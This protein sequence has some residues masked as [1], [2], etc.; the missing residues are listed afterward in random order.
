MFAA[1]IKGDLSGLAIQGRASEEAAGAHAGDRPGVASPAPARRVLRARRRG[2]RHAA[3]RDRDLVR[4]AAAVEGARAQRDA[5]ELAGAGL[6]LR[7]PQQPAAARPEGLGGAAEIPD[8]RRGQGAAE[9]PGWGLQGHRRGDPAQAGRTRAA[10]RRRVLRRARVRH[11]RPAPADPGRPRRHLAA[12]TAQAAGPAGAVLDVPDVAAGRPLPRPPRGRR[13]RQAEAGVLLRRGAPAVQRSFNK[14]FVEADHADRASHPIQG[15]RYLLRHPDAQGRARG[16]ARPARVARPAPVAR[17]HAQRRQ[18]AAGHRRDLSELQDYDL[19]EG[20]CRAA[21]HRRGDR[22][23]AQP[24]RRPDP[25]GLDADARAAGVHGPAGG[26]RHGAWGKRSSQ[27]QAKYGADI[28]RESAYEV[29]N[30]RLQAGAAADGRPRGGGRRR[31]ART[32]GSARRRR[33]SRGARRPPPPERGSARAPTRRRAQDASARSA[34]ERSAEGDVRP[35]PRRTRAGRASDDRSLG[36]N[37]MVRQMV[38][39]RCGEIPTRVHLLA[40]DAAA[41][42]RR[43]PEDPRDLGVRWSEGG[44]PGRAGGDPRPRHTGDPRRPIGSRV[45][46]FRSSA[47]DGGGGAS[48]S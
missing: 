12:G 39:R 26:R 24:Q 23:G 9:E 19:A 43:R 5:G 20:A 46:W 35:A 10:G 27:M 36:Q 32:A 2:H 11:R 25:G 40:P 30:A 15:R 41:E 47:P 31:A 8:Q 22:H 7:R 17:P 3:A 18:G 28:D 16:R 4:P 21:G 33:P 38:A 48:G 1:D 13:P 42:R 37:T 6:P 14:A 45:A 29:L 44:A 34:A